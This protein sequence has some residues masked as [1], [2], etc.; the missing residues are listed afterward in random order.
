MQANGWALKELGVDD[1]LAL[2]PEKVQSL[3][4]GLT[5]RLLNVTPQEVARNL[6]Y[7]GG[8]WY[9]PPALGQVRG[10]S[11]K[12]AEGHDTPFEQ[13]HGI[14]GVIH[15]LETRK[16]GDINRLLAGTGQAGPASDYL[17]PTDLRQP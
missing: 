16:A 5:D 9:L 15:G 12:T 14:D 6:A 1:P 2:L 17:G 4:R 3:A 7:S 8:K 11:S 13:Q 10:I